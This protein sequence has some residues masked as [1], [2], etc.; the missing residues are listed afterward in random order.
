MK[1]IGTKYKFKNQIFW[2]EDGMICI[3]DQ[4]DGD[5]KCLSRTEAFERAKIFNEE[6]RHTTYPDERD[7]LCRCVVGL[8]D[9]YFEA[10][11]QGDPTDPIVR[12]QKLKDMRKVS[13][14]Y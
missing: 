13:M 9:A 8:R 1:K 3:E 11:T 2:A 12:K 10:K 5:F 6:L 4:R 7:E 14:V